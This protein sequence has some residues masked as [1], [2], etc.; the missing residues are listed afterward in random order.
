ML[1]PLARALHK[2]RKGTD[3]NQALEVFD[4]VSWDGDDMAELDEWQ[5]RGE[6]VKQVLGGLLNGSWP[7]VCAAGRSV[8]CWS[9]DVVAGV[10]HVVLE[11]GVKVTM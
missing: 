2:V 9:T 10:G 6:E 3:R 5:S 11:S 1:E 7:E 4:F 8:P